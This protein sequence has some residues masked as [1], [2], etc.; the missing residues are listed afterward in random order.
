M[1][2]NYGRYKA[3]VN[4][5]AAFAGNMLLDYFGIN[6]KT[7]DGYHSDLPEIG[8][9]APVQRIKRKAGAV[10]LIIGKREAGKTV[11]AQRLGQVFERPTYSISPEQHPPPWITEMEL[12]DLN[13]FPPRFSTVILDDIPAYMSSR[14]Y[15]NP[16]VKVVEGI[17][18]VVRHK[19]KI[20]LVFCT[21]TSSQADR[22][23]L[24]ADLVILK[25]FTSLYADLERPA[26]KKLADRVMPIFSE[27]S[28]AEQ[29]RCC[30]VFHDLYT[31]LAR[32]DHPTVKL[33]G[34]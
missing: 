2:G 10:I 25:P 19:R 14:D 22:Y 21:Q 32:I 24:D 20:F 31:G 17:I 28:E 29:K 1:Y 27:M 7:Y 33:L 18:P 13:K 5:L 3:K 15:H 9:I 11:L 30:Y 4:P 8:D 12:K 6:S 16:L 26:V 23:I 34:K